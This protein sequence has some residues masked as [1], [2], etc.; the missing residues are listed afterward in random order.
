MIIDIKGKRVLI[1]AASEGIGKGIAKVFA[2]EGCKVVIS[3]RSL[4]KLNEALKELRNFAEYIW[5]FSADL[6]KYET[7]ESLSKNVIEAL[8]GIDVLVIN[9]GNPPKEPAYFFET[10]IEDWEYST[11][12]YLLGPI[13]L[14]KLLSPYM[15]KQRWGRIIF[16]SS[17]TVKEPQNIFVLADV[18]RSPLIQLTK[19][20]S[21]ELG[22]YNITVNTILMGSFETPGAIKTLSRLA[23]RLGVEF[24]ELWEKVVISPSALGRTGDIERELGSLLVYLASDYSSYITGSYILIDGGTTRAI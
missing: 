11:K 2:K 16:L 4:N 18:S 1:T 6:T 22:K 24:K 9:S 13:Y 20:L 7:L 21:R 10:E 8:G 5:G 14:I 15:M 23:A 17:W 3:S 19:I 12:L